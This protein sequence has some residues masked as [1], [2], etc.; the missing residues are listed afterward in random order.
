[1]PVYEGGPRTADEENDFEN[2]VFGV[3]DTRKLVKYGNPRLMG[4]LFPSLYVEGKGF[5][6]LNYKGI[7]ESGANVIQH[8]EVAVDE[9]RGD[10]NEVHEAVDN[11]DDDEE[12]GIDFPADDNDQ[13]QDDME[14]GDATG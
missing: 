4:Y 6:S 14:D 2:L 8:H 9:L 11:G 10:N 7:D 5:Y 12:S 3:D 1:M 13:E